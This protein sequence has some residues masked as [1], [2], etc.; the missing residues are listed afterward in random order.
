MS[1]TKILLV[2]SLLFPV[3][4]VG[5]LQEKLI[6][7]KMGYICICNIDGTEEKMLHESLGY[8]IDV[9]PDGKEVILSGYTI[10]KMNSDGTNAHIIY[11]SADSSYSAVFSPDG[12]KIAFAQVAA[13]P[14]TGIFTM[15]SDG[16]SVT[17]LLNP[18]DYDPFGYD[19]LAP[20]WSADGEYIYFQKNPAAPY[21]ND[22]I[23]KIRPDGLGE[24][25]LV[26]APG[27]AFYI[28]PKAY[29]SLSR[30]LFISEVVDLIW[31]EITEAYVHTMNTDGTDT[32]TLTGNYIDPYAVWSPNGDKILYRAEGGLYTMNADGTDKQFTGISYYIYRPKWVLIDIPS[33]AESWENYP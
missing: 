13:P 23:W 33:T 8:D 29:P 28:D 30:I 4:A 32:R 19:A 26:A 3:V 6:Y 22:G 9:S 18:N 21:S 15:N 7:N 16:T 31:Q 5:E 12:K 27:L 24:P 17:L 20:T 1:I 14:W 11:S 25:E 2:I 10:W